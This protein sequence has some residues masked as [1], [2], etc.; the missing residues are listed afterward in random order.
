MILPIES[1]IATE[2]LTHYLLVF[3]EQNDKSKFLGKGGYSLD[4]WEVLEADLRK[5]LKNEA[6]FQKEDTFGEY[7]V[8]NGE[9]SNGLNVKTIWLRES[10][11][12]VVRFIT[13]IPRAKF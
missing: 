10:G 9:L 5:L 1:V 8:I 4:N 3:N 2:K 12:E 6:V 11:S 13:L 7:F